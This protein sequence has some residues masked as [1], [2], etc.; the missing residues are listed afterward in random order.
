MRMQHYE[1]TIR[2]SWLHYIKRMI[3]LAADNKRDQEMIDKFQRAY[4]S[5]K[6]RSRIILMTV[7]V[8]LFVLSISFSGVFYSSNNSSIS[9]VD[10]RSSSVI[11]RVKCF[12]T[13]W[14][15]RFNL[16]DNEEKKNYFHFEKLTEDMIV[17]NGDLTK[18]KRYFLL[19]P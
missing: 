18:Y 6:K 10:N 5:L 17:I 4:E 8:I 2:I 12:L 13:L 19:S 9:R 7:F 14:F 15:G 3:L 1:P 16:K 11:Y